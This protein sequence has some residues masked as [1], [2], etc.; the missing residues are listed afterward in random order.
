MSLSVNPTISLSNGVEIP[1]LGFGTYLISE[2]KEIE[3]ALH[4]AF[5]AGYR[6]IDTASLYKN[7]AGVGR[8]IKQSSIPREDLFITTKVWNEDQRT[9]NVLAAFEKSMDLLALDYVDLYLVHWPVEGKYVQSWKEVEEIYHSGRAKAIG[10]SNHIIHHLEDVLAV[11]DVVPMVNQ[12][13]YQPYLTQPELYQFCKSKNII[14]EA[15]SPLMQGKIT[16]VDALNEIGKK[17]GKSPA[18]VTIRWAIQK[19]VITIPKSSNPGRM[20]E[21]FDVFDFELTVD[22]ISTIDGLNQSKRFGPDPSNFDF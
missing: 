17:H 1:L 10:V 5:E 8:A 7:E 14:L 15:W 2:G 19:G 4:H 12:I 20:K 13:E 3:T 22:E 6:H 21:N 11:C 9:D 16:A 18:Q